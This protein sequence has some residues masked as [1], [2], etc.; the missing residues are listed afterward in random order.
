M[1]YIETVKQHKERLDNFA[2]VLKMDDDNPLKGSFKFVSN[3]LD[4]MISSMEFYHKIYLE[5][6][7]NDEIIKHD[8]SKTI[9]GE[10]R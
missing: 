5:G 7:L 9:Q 10:W 4:S 2:S 8:R 3:V 6:E 1:G